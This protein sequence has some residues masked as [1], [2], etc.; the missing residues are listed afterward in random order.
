MKQK[1]VL[2]VSLPARSNPT[3]LKARAPSLQ[4]RAIRRRRFSGSASPRLPLYGHADWSRSNEGGRHG[5]GTPP[6]ISV[7]SAGSLSLLPEDGL[8]DS[9]SVLHPSLR[10]FL[11]RGRLVPAVAPA[12]QDGPRSSTEHSLT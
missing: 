1:P 7:G 5:K 9:R 10:V 11:P 3:I 12:T 2:L 6:L 8:C 4:T